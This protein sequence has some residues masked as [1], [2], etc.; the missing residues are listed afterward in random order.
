ME[1]ASEP[2][3]PAAPAPPLD[4]SPVSSADGSEPSP[5]DERRWRPVRPDEL[6]RK[7]VVAPP[8]DEKVEPPRVRLERRQT[9]EHHLKLKPTD[10]EAFLELAKIYRS[11]ERPVE[12]KRILQQA[13]Q[14][15]PDDDRLT[16]E[17]EEATLAR[18]LQQ[19]REVTELASRL[20]TPEADR[21]LK[22]SQSD[23]ACRRMDV[24]RARLARD[25]SL[26]HLHLVL[27][28]ALLDA[29]LFEPAVET[30]Q[31]VLDVDEYSPQAYLLSG[32]AMLAMGKDLAAMPLLR[33]AALRRAVPA[34]LRVRVLALRLLCETAERLGTT[35]TLERYRRQLTTAEHELHRDLHEHASPAVK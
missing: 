7:N 27:A 5:L 1:S 33:A 13:I 31:A 12:A 26:K 18:S 28:E 10:L 25:P 11:E 32:R 17:L 24:C 23:W 22:R 4:A 3:H 20:N 16:W 9:L 8:E 19:L 2:S 21:E 6:L 34:P 15:F 35:M 29:G 30:L 14:I